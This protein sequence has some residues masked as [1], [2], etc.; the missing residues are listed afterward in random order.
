MD[1]SSS[2]SDFEVLSVFNSAAAVVITLSEAR[3]TASAK[4][5]GGSQPGRAKNR[6]FS[7]RAK[8]N[9]L[10]RDLF[11]RYHCGTPLF[12]KSEFERTHQMTRD[13]HEKM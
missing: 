9:Q 10:D 13:M 3:S 4:F 6:N 8:C 7:V 12:T 11:C 1:S 2:D 5:R